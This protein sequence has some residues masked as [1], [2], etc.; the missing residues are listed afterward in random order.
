M[1]REQEG[2]ATLDPEKT[3]QNALLKMDNERRGSANASLSSCSNGAK[4]AGCF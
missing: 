3:L 2:Q 1:Q 4:G